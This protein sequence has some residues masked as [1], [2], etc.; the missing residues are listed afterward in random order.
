ML[1]QNK[2][3]NIANL[4]NKALYSSFFAQ[5]KLCFAIIKPVVVGHELQKRNYWIAIWFFDTK[6]QNLSTNGQV[7]IF[8]NYNLPL[9]F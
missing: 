7:S 5:R 4:I 8:S 3:I 2:S 6:S 9:F 1:R